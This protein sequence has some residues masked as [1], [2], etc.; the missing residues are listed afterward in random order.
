MI[1]IQSKEASGPIKF[2]VSCFLGSFTH[3]QISKDVI[4]QYCK[5]LGDEIDIKETTGDT[6]TPLVIPMDKISLM[7]FQIFLNSLK[8]NNQIPKGTP[9]VNYDENLPAAMK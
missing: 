8:I 4:K 9:G 3:G 2:Q 5:K 7:K 1:T 6:S